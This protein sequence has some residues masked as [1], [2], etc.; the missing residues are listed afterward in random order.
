MSREE[1]AHELPLWVTLLGALFGIGLLVYGLVIVLLREQLMIQSNLSIALG[2]AL[3]AIA[4]GTK[5]KVAHQ[6]YY[7]VGGVDDTDGRPF[8][9]RPAAAQ[10]DP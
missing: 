7:M 4:F 8:V 1:R 9:R 3:I 5:A 2:M 6:N 10:A